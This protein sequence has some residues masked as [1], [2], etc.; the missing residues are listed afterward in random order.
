MISSSWI[1][2][3]G[4]QWK[5]IV[6]YALTL[7]T[8]FMLAGG[9]IPAL[10]QRVMDERE[11]FL[12]L[13]GLVGV[14]WLGWFALAVRCMKCGGRPGLW[15]L[16]N[17]RLTEWFTAFLGSERCPLCHDEGPRSIGT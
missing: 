13:S 16:Q 6:L 8:L 10:G 17:S 14:V 2:A 12:A 9:L 7:L 4:Q 3:T 1:R 11:M 15:Y 5:L